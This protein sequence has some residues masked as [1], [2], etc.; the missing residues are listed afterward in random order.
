MDA[1]LNHPLFMPILV[2]LV[3]IAVFPLM[4]GYI[5]LVERKVLADYQ[6]RLGPMRVGPHGLLQPI[7][8]ALKLLL[9]EDIIPADS[10]HAIFWFA[11]VISTFTGLTAFTVLP[12]AQKIFVADVNVGLLVVS[13]MSAVGI[14][15]I[16]LG[17]W[18]SNSHYPLLGALRSAAQLV[19]YEVAL[20]FALLSGVMAAGTLSMQGIVKAQLD[21]HV[22][23]IFDNYFFMIV[24]FAVY[25]IAAT[26]ETNRAPFD[27]PEAESELVAGFHT[28]YSG[29]RWALYF[30]AEY[31]NIFV[32]SAVAVTLF[33]GGWLRP[34]PGIA[35]LAAP[36]NYGVPVVLLAGSGILTFPLVKK[37]KDPMQQK[38]LVG[39]AL[40]LIGMAALF[41]IP[42]V[43]N[44]VIGLFWF[45]FKI[46][47]IVY[48]MIW[49]R[50]TFPRFRYDQLMNIGW[51]VA[52]PVGMGAVVVNALLGM[53]RHP[54]A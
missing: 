33:W 50:G 43:N 13:A 25:I 38:V 51:K 37:L 26:A 52:I 30:L 14:L 47:F 2:T 40:L 18:A 48:L 42:V 22:W 24:P 10:D 44:A 5:V 20:A 28:E 8:D 3:V 39:A 35:W 34:F 21:R 41:A 49:F 19:S 27:L 36:L 11:P 54:G 7:A 9:K 46:S 32:V 1:V 15:G 53:W 4:A 31:A 6:V 17:G 23:F 29:F 45:L 12:F 16:I